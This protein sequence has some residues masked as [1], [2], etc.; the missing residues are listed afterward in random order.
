MCRDK[1]IIGK[2]C[3]IYPA[4]KF[5]A[6]C[7]SLKFHL[8]LHR[9]HWSYRLKRWWPWKEYHT[10]FWYLWLMLLCI[11][12]NCEKHDISFLATHAD[13]YWDIQELSGTL[14][15]WTIHVFEST[16]NLF[17]SSLKKLPKYAKI[18]IRNLPSGIYQLTT[19]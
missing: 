12:N 11:S 4:S 5:F 19:F 8:Y 18:C 16:D 14:Q 15:N 6:L 7:N 17:A 1:R 10:L 3:G 2:D 13:T 9:R